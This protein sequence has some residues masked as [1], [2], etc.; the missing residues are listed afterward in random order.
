ML[1]FLDKIYEQSNGE[2]AMLPVFTKEDLTKNVRSAGVSAGLVKHSE[3]DE[4]LKAEAKELCGLCP[5]CANYHTYKRRDGILWPTD[6]LFK[7]SQFHDMNVQQRASVV[8]RV[9]CCSSCTSWTHKLDDCT[10]KADSCGE[11]MSGS[12]CTGDH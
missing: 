9:N 2:L 4:Y 8:E 1:A 3:D 7:C 10:M 6:R 11:N 5:V 12:K